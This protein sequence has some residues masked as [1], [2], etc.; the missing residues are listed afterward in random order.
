ML[1]KV[2]KNMNLFNDANS[3]LGIVQE[4]T[5]PKISH[6]MEDYRAGGMLGPIKIDMGLEG[7]ECDWSL[8]GHDIQ[9]IRQMGALQHDAV[10]LRFMGAYQSDDDGSV[11]AVE[12]VMRGRHQELDRGGA[13]PGDKTDFKVKTVLSYYEEFVNG[14]QLL[15]IDMARAIYVVGGVDRYAEIRQALGLV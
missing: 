3:Y 7:L 15:Q 10:L 12:I 13:K 9:T 11:A 5:P 2:L 6:K 8:G 14:Q 4:L 1:P